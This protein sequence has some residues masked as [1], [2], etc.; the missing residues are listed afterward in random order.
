VSSLSFAQLF[1]PYT[2]K[3]ET[4][5]YNRG[6]YDTMEMMSKQYREIFTDLLDLCLP[7]TDNKSLLIGLIEEYQ[8]ECTAEW[9]LYIL[10]KNRVWIEPIRTDW[11]KCLEKE[12]TL[13][14]F[15]LWLKRL[16]NE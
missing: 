11:R 10:I 9:R 8:K 14:G 13:E 16:D 2:T 5:A 7:L 1:S 15:K 4:D 3:V 12:P 6:K